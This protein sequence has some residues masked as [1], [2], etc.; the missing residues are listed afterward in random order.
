MQDPCAPGL[1]RPI[2][3]TRQ[4]SPTLRPC[5]WL[6][7]IATLTVPQTEQPTTAGQI[8][9][10]DYWVSAKLKAGVG[11][12]DIK[13][14]VPVVILPKQAEEQA[15]SEPPPEWRPGQV[16]RQGMGKPAGPT[17]TLGMGAVL[18]LTW[19]H[20]FFFFI[21]GSLMAILLGSCSTRVFTLVW[22]LRRRGCRAAAHRPRSR[23]TP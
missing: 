12:S 15:L 8:V 16:R 2:P 22:L 19:P 1:S 14:K 18:L 23:A 4:Q 21:R 7:R 17:G 6:C 13:V 10:C 3:H 9:H 20:C 11:L 5:R